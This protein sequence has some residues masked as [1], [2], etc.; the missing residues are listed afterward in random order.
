[1]CLADV[2]AMEKMSIPKNQTYHKPYGEVVP[3]DWYHGK[4]VGNQ[5]KKNR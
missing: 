4:I 3:E 5:K 2:I 1:M